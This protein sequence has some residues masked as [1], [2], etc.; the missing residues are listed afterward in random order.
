MTV[1][2]NAFGVFETDIEKTKEYYQ[3]RSLC[4]CEFC[5]AFYMQIKKAEPRLAE[6]LEEFGV[7]ASK[8]DE[9]SLPYEENGKIFYNMIDYTVCGR[10][11]EVAAAVLLEG[12][13]INLCFTNGHCSSNA[14]EGEYFTI[15]IDS[16]IV[17]QKNK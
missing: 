17:V 11:K 16:T 15:S 1:I 10:I 12:S 5:K 14:Q 13:D 3:N 2:K 6:F 9:I 4:E 8:P 7:D